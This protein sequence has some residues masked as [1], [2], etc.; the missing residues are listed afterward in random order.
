[1]GLTTV[2]TARI[3]RGQ[4]RGH[5]GEENELTFDKFEYVALAKTYNTNS[6][7]GDSGACATA[8][9]CGVKG[10]FETVGLD[11]SGIFEKCESSLLARIPCLAEWAQAEGKSTGLVTTTRVTHATPAAMYGHSASRYWES[12]AKIPEDSRSL[13]K[14]IARQLVENDPGRNINVILGGGRCHFLPK[15][16][17][18]IQIPTDMGRREDGQN[19]IDAWQNDKKTRGLKYKYVANKREFD[20]VDPKSTDYLLGLFNYGHMAYEVDRD[21]GPDGE[22][23]LAEMTRKSI[24]IL[25]KNPR[26]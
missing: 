16:E 14:D 6:Q 12:D 7:V 10:R 26:G 11:D 23:S 5:T 17:E 4:K 20:K 8:L 21:S 24:E 15:K 22:P 2:T 18:D 1:M 19:L 25:R 13:C 9:L 3:L